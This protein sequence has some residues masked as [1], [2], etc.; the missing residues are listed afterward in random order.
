MVVNV[1]LVGLLI[2]SAKYILQILF[3]QFQSSIII[4]IQKV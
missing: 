3:V 2:Q 4:Y 1:L